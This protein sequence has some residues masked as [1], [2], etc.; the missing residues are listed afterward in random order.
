MLTSTTT[1]NSTIIVVIPAPK[2]PNIW[3]S[4]YVSWNSTVPM[5]C[6]H[7]SN[8]PMNGGSGICACTAPLASGGGITC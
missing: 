3:T 8:H 4:G 2:P 1:N 7:C 6:V 5:C